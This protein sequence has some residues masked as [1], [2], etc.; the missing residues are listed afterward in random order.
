[1]SPVGSSFRNRLRMFPRWRIKHTDQDSIPLILS[2]LIFMCHHD[3]D[4]LQSDQL[5]HNRLVHRLAWRRPWEGCCSQPHKNDNYDKHDD[6]NNN[7]DDNYD[8]DDDNYDDHDDNDDDDHN[9]NHD[10]WPA[11]CGEADRGDGDGGGDE[12]AVCPHVQ[13][14]ADDDAG[15][16]AM[17]NFVS[18]LPR[19]CEEDERKIWEGDKKVSTP[20]IIRVRVN[21]HMCLHY[22]DWVSISTISSLS[23]LYFDQFDR[24]EGATMWPR[25][26]TSSWYSPS[27]P[28]WRGSATT[29]STWRP[30]TRWASESL[31][32]PPPRQTPPWQS[33]WLSS[34]SQSFQV[35]VMQNELTAL[36]PQLLETSDETEKLMIKI[37]Q[38]TIQVGN[39]KKYKLI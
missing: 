32:L 4:H 25:P 22:Q 1:M 12:G 17:I 30:V 35:T 23:L 20:I 28:C 10:D 3:H 39:I 11:G 5:V 16:D 13:G 26:P 38:D 33:Q 8:G 9:H 7:C 18:A 27:S 24:Y 15:D 34:Q 6:S 14:E 19:E 29:S 36:R 31:N 21:C 37:E 2:Y